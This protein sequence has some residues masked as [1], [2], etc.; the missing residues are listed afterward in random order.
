MS[1]DHTYVVTNLDLAA[2][3]I[4]TGFAYTTHEGGHGFFFE[5]AAEG[6]AKRRLKRGAGR[7][8][9]KERRFFSKQTIDRM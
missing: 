7:Y 1:A 4:E 8:G 9:A 5:A 2:W 6:A 3:L